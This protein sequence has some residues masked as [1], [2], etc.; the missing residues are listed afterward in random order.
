M[1]RRGPYEKGAAKRAEILDAALDVFAAEGYRGTS[2]R[3]VAARCELS[4]PGL[5][6][7][8]R[9]KED[10]LAQV[11]RARDERTRT[12]VRA[13]ARAEREVDAVDRAAGQASG[14]AVDPGE[15]PDDGSPESYLRVIRE[16]TRTP[17][18]VELF[19]SLAAAASDPAH[20]ARP[21]FAERYPALREQ[22][23]DCLRQR[24]D[25][26]RLATDIPP[27]RLAVLLIALVDGI[28]LQWLV[29]RSVDMEQPLADLLRL[30]EP[31][32]PA[33]DADR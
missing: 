11:L 25:T 8:F 17:G 29:D 16:G 10:L 28:Q 22:L 15:L 33:R 20:P 27:E 2:L 3:K 13:Q 1:A 21:H 26:G 14:Q 12:R 7:Y 32:E 30:L 6:H 5:M 9:S 23:A 19:V 4:L 24:A 31:T 18:L